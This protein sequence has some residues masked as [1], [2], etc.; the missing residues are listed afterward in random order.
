M[1]LAELFIR[2]FSFYIDARAIRIQPAARSRIFSLPPPSPLPFLPF[3]SP[4]FG[5]IVTG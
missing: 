4:L 3:F 2:P 1:H 5:S